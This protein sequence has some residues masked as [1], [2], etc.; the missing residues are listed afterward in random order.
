MAKK[1][2]KTK[3]M[4]KKVKCIAK[5]IADITEIVSAENKM[6][7]LMMQDSIY[8]L[9][10]IVDSL[11]ESNKDSSTSHW[12]IDPTNCNT[13]AHINGITFTPA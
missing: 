13:T 10:L 4:G 8:A 5:C 2:S 11:I 7:I 3:K 12:K 6:E 1:K 9:Q